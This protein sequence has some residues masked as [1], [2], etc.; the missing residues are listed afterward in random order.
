MKQKKYL[1]C[2]LGLVMCLLLG[3]CG[4]GSRRIIF[5]TGSQ[6]D[7]VFR[8]NKEICHLPEFL[9]YLTSTQRQYESVYG[10]EIWNTEWDGF[11]LKQNVKE[12]VLEKIAQLK[13]MYLMAKDRKIQL[14]DEEEELVNK[15]AARYWNSLSQEERDT[16]ALTEKIVKELYKEYALADKVY[17]EIIRDV[18]PEISDDDARTVTIQ[19][20]VFHTY[21]KDADGNKV[22]M[23]G[24]EKNTLY[25]EAKEVLRLATEEGESF[26]D[27]AAKYSDDPTVTY[28]VGKGDLDISLETVAFRL[29]RDEISDVIE[30]P[31]GYHI[32]KCI[33]T[34]DREQTDEN[35]KKLLEER[36]KEAFGKEY[37]AFVEK[38]V[39]SL[40]HSVWD[41]VDFIRVQ[42]PTNADFFQIYGQFFED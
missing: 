4:D 7:E 9:I 12:T 10:E 40:N 13:T 33:N 38:L 2:I 6:K 42:N 36:K 41:N 27:L 16:M 19:H 1:F 22:E 8:I 3:A 23:T 35:K 30:S 24:S 39:Q 37:E 31:K 28:Y 29:V 11:S 32:L 20:I 26:T 5:T 15:A 34:L 25:E 17:Q 18:N 21:S 14:T